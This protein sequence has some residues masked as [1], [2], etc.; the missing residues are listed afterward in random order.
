MGSRRNTLSPRAFL[1]RVPV[2]A[3]PVPSFCVHIHKLYVCVC[4]L[5]SPPSTCEWIMLLRHWCSLFWS[6]WR[7]RIQNDHPSTQ[8]WNYVLPGDPY[9]QMAWTIVNVAILRDLSWHMV[10]FGIYKR[11]RQIR[12]SFGIPRSK[13]TVCKTEMCVVLCCGVVWCVARVLTINHAHGIVCWRQFNERFCVDI[14]DLE[15]HPSEGVAWQY[16]SK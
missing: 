8:Q 10:L 15:N 14:M 1:V 16:M 3:Y 4:F 13:S 11:T 5:V 9:A 6:R 12:S 2:Y 7:G